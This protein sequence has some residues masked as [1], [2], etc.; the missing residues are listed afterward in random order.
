MSTVVRRPEAVYAPGLHLG[1]LDDDLV[2]AVTSLAGAGVPVVIAGFEDAASAA[3]R[4]GEVPDVVV[5]DADRALSATPDRAHEPLWERGRG[6]PFGP[7]LL[8][9]LWRRGIGPAGL[10]V[11]GD[12]PG[13]LLPGSVDQ[14][15]ARVDAGKGRARGL[16]Q[17]LRERCADRRDGLL[18][19]VDEYAGWCV[20]IGPDDRRPAPVAASLLALSGGVIGVPGDREDHPSAQHLVLAAGAFGRGRDGSE[21]PLPG[22]AVTV[23]DQTSGP[24]PCRWVLDLH[25]GVLGREPVDGG[26]RTVRFVSVARPGVVA[27]RG[28][29]TNPGAAWPAALAAPTVGVGLTAEHVYAGVDGDDEV[30]ARTTDGETTVAA[31][32]VQREWHLPDRRRVERIVSVRTSPATAP[33]GAD[34]ALV[35]A[36]AQGFD[37]LLAEHRR[38]WAQRWDGADIEIDGDPTTQLAVRHALFQILSCAPTEG[39]A[40]VGAR[41]LTG[42]AY[43]GHVFWDTDV[44]VLPALAATLP[45]AARA[46]LQY[47]INRLDTARDA[48]ASRGLPGARFPW[49]S[50]ATGR[51]VTPTSTRDVEG[52]I[53]PIRTG[54][55]EEHINADIAWAVRHYLDWTGDAAVLEDGGRD[56]VLETARCWAARVRLDQDEV[57]HLYGVIGPDEYHEIVDDNAYTNNLTRWHLQWAA[58]LASAAGAP[59]EAA[60]FAAVAGSLVTGFDPGRG[61]HEQFAGFWDL[62]PLLIGDVADTPV[63]ADVLLGRDRV[64]RTQV[65]KQPDVLMLH[66]LLPDACPPGS[67]RAD[68]DLYLPRTAHGSSLS[69]AICAGLLARD[70][71]PDD[72]M[73][74]VDVAAG[75]DL[76][77]RGGMTAGGLHLATM[78]GLWQ[79]VVTGFA[80]I[81]PTPAGLA[82]DP[83]LPRR[84]DRLSIRLRY[85]GRP[86]R[87][88]IDHELVDIEADG[89]VP[90]VIAGQP[91]RSPARVRY[92]AAREER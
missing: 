82:V 63:A 46:V 52:H 69:P 60:R 79:A 9:H 44:F 39:E 70:G 7:W 64:R 30:L 84:W 58:E 48:A 37:R 1:D 3:R 41:G 50:A 83:R 28:E 22:P 8:R 19:D 68:L 31:A 40:V 10:T 88:T 47:R 6:E 59:D 15:A 11:Y 61:C 65:V 91:V 12:A 35:A 4:L 80:G 5:V 32:A 26:L 51:D 78:G 77:D 81:R 21:L 71:R 29:D 14:R 43:A 62:E 87:V 72:A 42:L 76:D 85:R 27:L 54:E 66:H 55:H 16:V 36:R 18:P 73:D 53:V 24:Q 38:A 57:G 56:L 92:A 90:V 2:A 45:A 33:H 49:E 86:V 74:L 25:A 67:L 17:F 20:V 75:V 34:P 23:L 89:P 13:L